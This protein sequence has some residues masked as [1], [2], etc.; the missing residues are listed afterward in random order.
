M[1]F[2]LKLKTVSIWTDINLNKSNF[3][4]KYYDDNKS[5][6]CILTPSCEIYKMRFWEEYFFKFNPQYLM[7]TSNLSHIFNC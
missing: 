7:K 4:N 3:I 2:Y 1:D 6:S 5:K